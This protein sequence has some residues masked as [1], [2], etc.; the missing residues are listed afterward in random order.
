VLLVHREI[1][2]GARL[3][4]GSSKWA[5]GRRPEIRVFRLPAGGDGRDVAAVPI[6]DRSGDL[7]HW[8]TL[9]LAVGRRRV[10]DHTEP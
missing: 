6:I 8:R 2:Q 9:A 3:G 10:R 4:Q 5:V 1:A 7:T